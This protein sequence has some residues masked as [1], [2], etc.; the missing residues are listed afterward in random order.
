M[1]DDFKFSIIPIFS[2]AFHT[3]QSVQ[4]FIA[5]KYTYHIHV[6]CA[7]NGTY[8]IV[9]I[10]VFRN[11]VDLRVPAVLRPSSRNWPLTSL[12]RPS[13]VEVLWSSSRYICWTILRLYVT[14]VLGD[15]RLHRRFYVS[16][17]YK[18]KITIHA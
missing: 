10:P 8:N 9:S 3:L 14:Q 12:K 15:H 11:T 6:A 7:H 5:Q 4:H 18:F 2:T 13:C 16:D 17:M 1:I